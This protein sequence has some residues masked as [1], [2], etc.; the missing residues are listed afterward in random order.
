M[1]EET[2]PSFFLPPSSFRSNSSATAAAVSADEFAAAGATS[3]TTTTQLYSRYYCCFRSASTAVPDTAGTSSDVA[4]RANNSSTGQQQQQQP[5]Q[6]TSRTMSTFALSF[7]GALLLAGLLQVGFVVAAQDGR[8]FR[9]RRF[10]EP[11]LRFVQQLAN[12][13][14]GGGGGSSS[15]SSRSGQAQYTFRILQVAD[16]HLGE[17]SWTDWGPE[18]DRKTWIALDAVID[19]ER[20]DLVLLTGDQLTAN[21]IDRNATAYQELLAE[22]LDRHGIPWATVFGN[23]DDAPYENQD[24]QGQVIG[25]H[26]AKTSRR[27][28]VRVDQRHRLSLT[29]AGPSDVFGVSNYWLDVLNPKTSKVA[30]RLAVLD[31]GGGTLPQQITQRQIDWF[32]E[33][34]SEHGAGVPVFA[35]QHIPAQQF[36]YDGDAC[37]GLAED[38]VAAPQDGDAG[39]VSAFAAAN[40][41]G[42]ANVQLL[43]AGHN[44]GNDYCCAYYPSSGKNDNNNEGGDGVEGNKLSLCFGRHSGYGGYGSWD[45][46]SRVYRL[47]MD[48]DGQFLGW[49]SYVR[50][51]S[52][53]VAN[54]YDPSEY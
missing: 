10:Y 37:R 14:G 1:E 54:E 5:Q 44:H 24:E 51:E 22:R 49:T 26:P 20:P 39:I 28:L 32:F 29:K 34:A 6:P 50:M 40:S 48:A 11:T 19:A 46:G 8:L 42:A 45:R 31:S 35:F 27:Q 33:R 36:A 47:E 21:N 12:D 25:V 23:H 9:L 18:Q 17:N 2:G 41:V 15:S 43:A 3:S 30:A 16:I 7:A 52:G 13:D 53:E 4:T 38:G